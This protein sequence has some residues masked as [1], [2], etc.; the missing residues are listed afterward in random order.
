MRPPDSSAARV[1]IGPPCLHSAAPRRPAPLRVPARRQ[2]RRPVFSLDRHDQPAGVRP[3]AAPSYSQTSRPS[4][5]AS[6][7]MTSAAA[8]SAHHHPSQ[9]SGPRP[10]AGRGGERA[11]C[12]LGGISDQGRVA[13]RAPGAALGHG[14]RWH[15]DQGGPA[16]ARPAADCPGR[17]CLIRSPM[18]ST[19]RYRA[20][21][22]NV[23]PI[24]RTPRVSRP[25]PL[26]AAQLPDHDR[27]GEELDHRVQAEPEQRDRGGQHPGGDRDGGLGRH[28]G[29]A[30]VLQPE[31]PADAT[32][33]ARNLRRAHQPA[34]S[35][36][37]VQPR[38]RLP[39]STASAAASRS[40]MSLGY[41]TLLGESPQAGS[42]APARRRPART[43]LIGGKSDSGCDF[44]PSDT[45]VSGST[46]RTRGRHPGCTGPE[47]PERGGRPVE[48]ESGPS[49]GVQAV[50]AIAVPAYGLVNR[51]V[52]TGDRQH[53]GRRCWC[54]SRSAG[55][56][57]CPR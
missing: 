2:P 28:P 32:A 45:E 21:A 11:E 25:S 8:G 46:S 43:A 44:V 37:T 24:R 12:R 3:Q 51:Q 56:A 30:G 42:A 9:V 15:D 18:P 13:E 52:M 1:A 55:T 29:H 50:P 36:G 19:A 34:R 22:K 47:C 27:G 10:P 20:S 31:N 40:S 38:C 53:S 5:A 48:R 54:S 41:G 33:P 14:Q 57:S 4:L 16:T 35:W 23:T 6:A 7:A 26:L 17:A 49:R 39:S